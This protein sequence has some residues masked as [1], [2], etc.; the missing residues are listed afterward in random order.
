M[1]KIGKESDRYE[2][3]KRTAGYADGKYGEGVAY[4]MKTIKVIGCLI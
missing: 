3:E 1:G 2:I 4:A